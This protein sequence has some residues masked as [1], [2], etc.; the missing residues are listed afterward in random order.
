MGNLL[1]L[2]AAVQRIV[3]Q[4]GG[5]LGLLRLAAMHL[6]VDTSRRIVFLSRTLPPKLGCD[7]LVGDRIL[8]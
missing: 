5:P 2:P 1:L 3:N 8:T 4:A 6:S 7:R